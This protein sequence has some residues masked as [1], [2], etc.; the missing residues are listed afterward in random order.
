MQR[1]HGNHH[2]HHDGCLAPGK[3]PQSR[4]FQHQTPSSAGDKGSP[5]DNDDAVDDDEEEEAGKGDTDDDGDDNEV[6]F[7]PQQPS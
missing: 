1:F 7:P 4:Q 2:N 3:N 6:P 5:E